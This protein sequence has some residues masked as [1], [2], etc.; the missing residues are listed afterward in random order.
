MVIQHDNHACKECQ[1]NLPSFM[2][3]LKHVA[4]HLGR[5]TVEVKNFED[6]N[7]KDIQ[8]KKINDEEKIYKAKCFVFSETML[9]EFI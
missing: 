6:S 7:G 9:D 2:E 4:K 5:E 3:L 8:N 1:E